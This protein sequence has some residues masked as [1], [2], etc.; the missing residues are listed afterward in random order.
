[1]QVVSLHPKLVPRGGKIFLHYFPGYDHVIS[2]KKLHC[3]FES[4]LSTFFLNLVSRVGENGGDT[5]Y[6]FRF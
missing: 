6:L 1:M 4:I 2:S 5:E 3:R